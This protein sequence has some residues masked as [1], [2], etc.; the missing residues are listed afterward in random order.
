MVAIS[1]VATEI[2]QLASW[3]SWQ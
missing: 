3:C 1:R 2:W